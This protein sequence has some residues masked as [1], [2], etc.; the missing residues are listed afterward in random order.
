MHFLLS[1]R[2]ARASN[3]CRSPPT[4]YRKNQESREDECTLSPLPCV[5]G[6]D[7][8]LFF[9]FFSLSRLQSCAVC[10]AKLSQP[11]PGTDLKLMDKS[12]IQ[13][14]ETIYTALVLT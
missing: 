14:S 4:C 1:N 10:D 12:Q 9:F 2:L 5:V 3:Q 13:S 6:I 7:F 8:Q 11:F